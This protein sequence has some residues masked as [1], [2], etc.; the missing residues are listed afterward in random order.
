M[1]GDSQLLKKVVV[2]SLQN[3]LP[4]TLNAFQVQPEIMHTHTQASKCI[5]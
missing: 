1:V 4:T 5:L 2:Q 3:F